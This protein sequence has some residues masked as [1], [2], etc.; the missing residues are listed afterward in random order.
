MGRRKRKPHAVTPKPAPSKSEARPTD[1]ASLPMPDDALVIEALRAHCG[2]VVRA[3][4]AL[5]VSREWLS[6]KV[7]S[8]PALDAIRHEASRYAFDVSMHGALELVEDGDKDATLQVLRLTGW[9]YG[10]KHGTS[11]EV[12]GP[13]GGP[14]EVRTLTPTDADEIARSI[15]GAPGSDGDA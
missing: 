8:D 9:R 1:D 3:A 13:D 10:F 15:Y 6:R 12:S 5:G 4:R 11:Q 14:I 2:I 7:N